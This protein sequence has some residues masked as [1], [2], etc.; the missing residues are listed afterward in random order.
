MK[1]DADTVAH[2]IDEVND[3]ATKPLSAWET[4]FME[5]I[6]DQWDRTGSLS[7]RQLEI[8]EHIYAEKTD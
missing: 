5:S 6:T 7:E 4:S 1:Y 3:H 8:L 2:F